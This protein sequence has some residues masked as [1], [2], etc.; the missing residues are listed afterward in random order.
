MVIW[1]IKKFFWSI[2]KFFFRFLTF[3]LDFFDKISDFGQKS[4]FLPLF[5]T[6]YKLIEILYY[7]NIFSRTNNNVKEMFEILWNKKFGQ[8]NLSRNFWKQLF[9]DFELFQH[10]PWFL[11]KKFFSEKICCYKSIFAISLWLHRSS[12]D[13]YRVEKMWE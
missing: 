11:R 2:E 10:F 1:P 9:I 3:F 7:H 4:V 12:E 8:K 5:T 13:D 6:K